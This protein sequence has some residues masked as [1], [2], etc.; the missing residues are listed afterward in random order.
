MGRKKLLLD[1]KNKMSS[2]ESDSDDNL[3]VDSDEELQKAF[4]RGDL[5]PGLNAL[6]AF[7]PREEHVYDKTAIKAKLDQLRLDLDWIERLDSVDNPAKVTA[8]VQQMFGNI[9][10]KLN[11]KG[12]ISAEEKESLDK[13]DNDFKREM[14]F[15]RRAQTAVLEGI[16]RL[17]ALKVVTKRPTDYFAEMSKT[18]DH[19]KKV[20]ENIVRRQTA[21]DASEKAKKMRDLK[22]Y[23][24]KIQTEVLIKRQKEKR[25]LM[26]R[27]KKYKTGKVLLNLKDLSVVPSPPVFFSLSLL[28]LLFSRFFVFRLFFVL[29]F[30]CKFGYGGQKKRSKY[31]DSSSSA[32]MNKFSRRRN[33]KP[34][35]GKQRPGKSSRQKMRNKKRS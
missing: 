33:A 22:K 23:G 12:E 14:L 31:N 4:Q 13:S 30:L 15:Y 6:V 2:D 3:S 11:K 24:K 34:M 21:K 9:D 20:R 1:L 8:E 32:E 18:D 26:D 35:A 29:M 27:L 5:K 28:R 16:P 19:M 7:K 17:R 25:E 10:L